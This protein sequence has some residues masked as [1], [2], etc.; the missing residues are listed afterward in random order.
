MKCPLWLVAVT[1]L[2]GMPF[3]ARSQLPAMCSLVPFKSG[4]AASL[5]GAAA[6]TPKQY[7]G[8]VHESLPRFY[9]SIHEANTEES[10]G[11]K[12]ITSI[13]IRSERK[14]VQIIR[15]EDDDDAPI[16]FA[17]G[18]LVTLEDVDC[19]GYKD[20]L[21]RNFVGV[22]GDAW[23]HLYRF[24]PAKR[25]FVEYGPFID[26]AYTGVDCRTK[27]VKTYE[28]NGAAGCIYEAGWYRW[29]NGELLPVR[30][31]SQDGGVNGSFLRTITVWPDGN[32]IVLSTQAVPLDDCH[33]PNKPADK[34]KE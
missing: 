14:L 29:I 30:V 7:S 15:F 26:L 5:S 21:V 2:L 19:D 23:Y 1:L 16:D 32:A 4:L 22:H 18:D 20:L 9:F 12:R 34:H 11:A 6:A 27:V 17:P 10:N 3:E 24:D 31:E 25:Q 8:I 28:N 13:K 33:V